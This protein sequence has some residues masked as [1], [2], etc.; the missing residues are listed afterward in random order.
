MG[1]IRFLLLSLLL[2][3]LSV[4]VQVEAQQ[5]FAV[6]VASVQSRAE[7]VALVNGLRARGLRA[8]WIRSETA[9]QTYY[10]IRVGDQFASGKSAAEFGRKLAREGAVNEYVVLKYEPPADSDYPGLALEKTVARPN[11]QTTGARTNG[12]SGVLAN[13]P[14]AHKVT[15]YLITGEPRQFNV[16]VLTSAGSPPARATAPPSADAV[17]PQNNSGGK[18]SKEQ[19]RSAD[20]IELDDFKE[21]APQVLQALV[22]P[23]DG[24]L[25]ITLR[26]RNTRHRFRGTVNLKVLQRG[27]E[28][29][30]API[31]IEIAPGAE[32]SFVAP[33]VGREGSYVMTVLDEQRALQLM[34]QGALEH[35]P[36]P[37]EFASNRSS[38]PVQANPL[39]SGGNLPVQPAQGAADS[40]EDGP[41]ELKTASYP[42]GKAE[43]ENAPAGEEQKEPNGE[44]GQPGDVRI[45]VRQVAASSEN[46]TIEFE[47]LASQPLGMLVMAVRTTSMSDSK[48]AI[49]TTK[50]GR[51]PFLVP[52]GD[53]TGALSYELKDENGR[54]L[55]MGSKAFQEI[56]KQ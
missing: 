9:G 38:Q 45:I 36:R 37:A 22:E 26:N 25:L 55:A 5:R 39:N 40:G 7:A 28:Q 2:V 10:R 31:Q 20:E 49:M 35:S 15:D 42:T 48:Q 23:R 6:Q 19:R 8:Y 4:T 51:L 13:T 12:G 21:F 33:G 43:D 56:P 34:Q 47:I 46:L 54:V 32:H 27:R 11:T 53:A 17:T 1:E 29:Q 3:W 18:G 14:A 50:Q 44:A 41:P 52:A 16:A 24:G 30:Q